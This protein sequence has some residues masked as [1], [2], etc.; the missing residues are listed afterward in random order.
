MAVAA[1]RTQPLY[2]GL[3][4]AAPRQTEQ[5]LKA[6]RA[7]RA[8]VAWLGTLTIAFGCL[9]ATAAISAAGMESGYQLD[10]VQQQLRAAQDDGQRLELQLQQ[11]GALQR[12]AAAA[13]RMGMHEAADYQ[14][15]PIVVVHGAPPLPTHSATVDL[16]PPPPSPPGEPFWAQVRSWFGR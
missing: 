5:H 8:F 4:E 1:Q 3:Q 2:V 16:P 7:R 10:A 14:T 6:A 12:V 9:A 11:A 15:L 13:A